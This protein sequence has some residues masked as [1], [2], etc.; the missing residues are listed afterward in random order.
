MEYKNT[1]VYLLRYINGLILV[2][3]S[4]VESPGLC[5]F[6]YL[7]IMKKVKVIW[8]LVCICFGLAIGYF[9]SGCKSAQKCDAYGIVTVDGYDYVQVIGYTDTVPVLG[10]EILYLPKGE[11]EIRMWSSNTS[12]TIKVKL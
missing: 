11:Y 6:V 1:V 5:Y 3:R 7:C 8:Y 4:G 9:L 10:Q 12:K 2:Q